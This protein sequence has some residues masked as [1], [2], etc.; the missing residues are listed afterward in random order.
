MIR[1]GCG[2]K[3]A[4]YGGSFDPIHIGHVAL[5]E[6]AVRELGLDKLIFMPT[7]I[8]PFK[9][10]AKA[11]DGR[12]R[13]GMIETVLPLNEAFCLSEYEL[14]KGGK[15]SYTIDT[16]THLSGELDGTLYFVLG[17]DSIVHIDTWYR[18]EEI[19]MNYPL[20]TGRRSDT[21]DEEGM[22]IIE[23]FRERYGADISV[24]EMAPVD[25]ASSDIRE[26]IR[27]GESISGL[28]TPGVEAYIEE[29]GLYR[30]EVPGYS[31]FC[32]DADALERFMSDNLKE[33]RYRHSLGVEKMAV[34]LAGIY[35]ADADKAGFA[36]RY[37]DIAKCFDTET[38]DSYIRKYS[39]DEDLLGDPALAHSKVGAAILEREFGVSDRDILNAVRYH[40]TAKKDMSLLE[41]ITY[42]ADVVE[43]NRTYPG[44]KYYQDLAASDLDRCTLE[45]LEYTISDL[46]GKN[47][48]IHKD[49]MEAYGY[50]KHKLDQ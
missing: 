1:S 11:A 33:S 44:L 6:A 9:L 22:R 7:Y 30:N 34:K 17:Y 14:K 8:S 25:A 38:M 26:M 49:T 10:D 47:R 5:A 45:I 43:E 16:L 27:R 29:H 32:S 46:N 13:C 41:Q 31:R 2:Q 18:G 39:L 3:Y 36:G 23:S 21:D 20:I 4:V 19:L 35:G 48:S 37:H 28:V 50:I 42:V 40:T 15:A 24:L 12:D